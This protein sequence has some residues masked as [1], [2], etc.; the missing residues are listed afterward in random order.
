MKINILKLLD[1]LE[2]LLE[3]SFGLF[4]K[5]IVD[6]EKLF[7]ISNNIRT[8][9]PDDIKE[10]V[11]ILQEKERIREDIR[12]EAEKI[13]GIAKENAEELVKESEI[14]KRAN[15]EAENILKE[16]NERAE[17][18]HK[19]ADEY[20]YKILENLESHLIKILE[21]VRKSREQI[22]SKE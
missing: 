5:I 22:T 13:L 20:A 8:S 15:Q 10:A 7:N 4:G 2:E 18:I 1:E 11:K 19:D 16:A 3:K 21:V 6:E 14:T 12:E 17:E 9:L